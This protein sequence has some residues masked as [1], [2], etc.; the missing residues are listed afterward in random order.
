MAVKRK[1]RRVLKHVDKGLIAEGFENADSEPKQIW[2]WQQFRRQLLDQ[3]AQAARHCQEIER[4]FGKSPPPELE[5]L[6]K[7]HRVII[8]QLSTQTDSRAARL[9]TALMKP[10][11]DWARLQE[12]RKERELA[13]AKYRD[14]V[15]AQKAALERELNAAKTAG[16]LSPETLE[17]IE[18]E[19][20]LM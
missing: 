8:L 1:N 20:K 17:K 16:G 4:E 15:A 19:L 7:L 3:I 5:T 9:V 12:H 13:E 2:D 10:V 11:M 18:R 6:I 14:L